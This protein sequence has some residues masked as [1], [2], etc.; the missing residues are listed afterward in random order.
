TGAPD[1]DRRLERT[2]DAIAV[3]L[4]FAWLTEVWTRGLT[5]IFGRMCLRA[6]TADGVHWTLDTVAPDLGET[7]PLSITID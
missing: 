5:T 1:G 6:N 7:A 2:S 4:P 3:T